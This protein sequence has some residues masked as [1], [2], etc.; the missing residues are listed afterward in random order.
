M[1]NIEQLE[2]NQSHTVRESQ[3]LTILT[4]LEVFSFVYRHG[5][6]I[7]DVGQESVI[8]TGAG[9]NQ[10]RMDRVLRYGLRGFIEE[11][12]HLLNPRKGHACAGYHK[13]E[14]Y[15]GSNANLCI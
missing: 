9:K 5:C 11:L 10:G 13:Q 3:G 8:I 2:S 14:H 12:P 4:R 6:T 1:A 15:V 7:P